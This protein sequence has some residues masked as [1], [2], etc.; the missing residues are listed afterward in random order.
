[1][2]IAVGIND[3]WVAADRDGDLFLDCPIGGCWESLAI[4][5][6]VLT[7]LRDLRVR[8]AEHLDEKHRSPTGDG[9]EVGK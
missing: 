8:A 4:D 9:M 1:M 3:F 5:M 6:D 7:T 2:P